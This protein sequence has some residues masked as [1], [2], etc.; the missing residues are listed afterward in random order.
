MIEL[1]CCQCGTQFER[2]YRI[3]SARR[4]RPQ[5]CSWACVGASK[6]QNK[7]DAELRFWRKVRILGPD[8]CWPW[9]GRLD[10][11]GYGRFDDGGLPMLA[12]RMA[13]RISTIHRNSSPEA[14]CH[15][16]DNPP[17]CNPAHLWAGTQSENNADKIA[18]GRG[19][20]TTRRGLACNM[21]RLDAEKALEAVSS[22]A[23]NRELAQRW[24]VSP[25]AI[26]N[27]RAGRSW[28]HVT[29]VTPDAQ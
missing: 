20:T 17:C 21:T 19:R 24:G 22:S 13:H 23:T 18:K 28:A 12:H 9:Q 29:G 26:Y 14:V 2:A 5:F 16:C 3:S 4:A 27:I 10:P 1:T 8:D 6:R 11:K 15:S 7:E 25:T